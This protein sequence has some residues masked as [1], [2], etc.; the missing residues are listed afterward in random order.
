MENLGSKRRRSSVSLPGEEGG[1]G[2]VTGT[3]GCGWWPYCVVTMS[4]RSCGRLSAV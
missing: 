2:G 3:A 1:G 4:W